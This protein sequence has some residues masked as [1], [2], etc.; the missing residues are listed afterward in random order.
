MPPPVM[1]PR[2]NKNFLKKIQKGTYFAKTQEVI[3]TT[4]TPRQRNICDEEAILANSNIVYEDL[5]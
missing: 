5:F 2:N 4:S 3:N 1:F